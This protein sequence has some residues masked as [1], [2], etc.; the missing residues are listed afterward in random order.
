MQ[1]LH[2]GRRKQMN[3]KSAIQ[4]YSYEKY[5]ELRNAKNMTDADVSKQTG[6]YQSTFTDWKNLKSMPGIEKLTK[7][8]RLFGVPLETFV[9]NEGE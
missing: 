2:I 4:K 8:S 7:L 6:I 3:T 9:P 1:I 5:T